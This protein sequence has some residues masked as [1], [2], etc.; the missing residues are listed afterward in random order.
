MAIFTASAFA[1]TYS[2]KQDGTG[3][4]TTIQDGINVA[5]NN[6]T[7]L[8]YP[9]TYYENIDYLEKSLTVASLYMIT[10]EDSLIN[11]T[12]IDG[13][14]QFR[15][16]TIE[17]CSSASL[18]GFTLQNGKVLGNGWTSGSG[19]G[20]LINNV[21]YSIVSNCKIKNNTAYSGG[22][23]YI[24][25]TDA[26]L[27]GNIISRNRGIQVAGGLCFTGNDT[28]VQF[29][30]TNLNSIFLNYSS[31]GA[32]IYIGWNI[33]G[34]V[35]IIADTLTVNEPD[36]FFVGPPPQCTISQLNAKIEEID[37]DLYVAPDGD[38]LNSGLS[39]DEPLQTLA[40]AQTLIKRNDDNPHTIFLAAGTYS[41][42]T[43]NQI[44]PLNV[45]KGVIFEGVSP[46]NTIID[47]E[48]ETPFVFQ[49]SP[50]QAEFSTLVMKNLKL[51]NG[52]C[53]PY[54]NGGGIVM[55]QADLHLDN[56]LIEDCSGHWSGAILLANGYCDINNTTISNNNGQCAVSFVIVD[57]CSNPVSEKTV[58]NSRIINNHPN[59][60]DPDFPGGGA[61]KISGHYS[62][63]GDYYA[64]FINCEISGNRNASYDPLSGLGGS[65]AMYIDDYANVDIV[66]CTIGDNVLDYNTG[67]SI[68]VENNSEVNIFNSILYDNDGY[69]FNLL[70]NAVVNI[71]HSLIEGGNGNVNYYYPLAIVNWLEGNLDE[72]PLWSGIGDY[73]YYLQSTSPC[74]DSGTTDLPTGIELPQYDLAG[75]PRI[76]GDTVDMG[77][78]EWQGV[79]VEEPEI[80]QLSLISTNISNYP[81]PFNPY[82][83][84][85]LELAEAGK[86]E[87]SVYNINGQKVKTLMDCTTSPGI[88]EC[89][90]YG[91]DET[92]K[93]VS[94]G[95]YVVKL[96][97]NGKETAK[98]IM[99]I[100]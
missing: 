64:K 33:Q 94:S 17:D 32:D 88:Y 43:N 71:S 93:S 55:Y 25:H 28:T 68:S 100:K 21:A 92:G 87:L 9:G 77:A 22:G 41:A 99:M 1:T 96:Q 59:I 86:I 6:D 19:G 46:G 62:I 60:I 70:E 72:Y 47:A 42:S 16:V 3:N 85:K 78:Y 95:Q 79:G 8:V 29:S 91:K 75:N 11:Q 45:K 83:T 54:L 84:I 49:F 80:P 14:E 76:Y 51:I 98:K 23:I 74:I 97:Q 65:A 39:Q 5:I 56:V 50:F 90:W 18:I 61:L 36:Y 4:F 12:I 34:I 7:I 2:I 66:N 40:W 58:T 37:Q 44:F 63:P 13:N 52:K 82:T 24:I 69:S 30:D 31:T 73:P 38:D 10:P 81:N 89:V 53:F 57:N 27:S 15:C 20:L 48:S 67:C 26:I 35:D